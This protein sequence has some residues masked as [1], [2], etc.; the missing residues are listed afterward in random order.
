MRFG[1]TGMR[2]GNRGTNGFRGGNRRNI[3]SN[4][5]NWRGNLNRMLTRTNTQMS[6]RFGN[7]A[8]TT[9]RQTANL[10][11]NTTQSNRNRQVRR[12]T[13]NSGRT[14]W[15]Q[16]GQNR[17]N[18]LTRSMFANFRRVNNR[19]IRPGMLRRAL[20]TSPFWRSNIQT[21]HSR[22]NAQRSNTR[23]NQVS[24]SRNNTGSTNRS[25]NRQ[26]YRQI[27]LRQ[28]VAPYRTIYRYVRVQ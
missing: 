4:S 3:A 25:G 2:L 1:N 11:R 19:N 23:T 18:I 6:R 28:R 12:N 16:R 13:M 5:N 9:Q 7:R 24:R 20:N 26:I 10:N 17:T 14:N 21:Q 27:A 22:G 15:R 8:R